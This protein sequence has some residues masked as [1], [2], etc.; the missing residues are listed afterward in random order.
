MKESL[1]MGHILPS[2]ASKSE[3][4]GSAFVKLFY[5]TNGLAFPS[6]S[7][8]NVINIFGGDL[9]SLKTKTLNTD[10]SNDLLC[11]K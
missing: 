11:I 10:C 9:D 5:F 3:A 6:K 2:P 4:K 8:A 1:S 7:V